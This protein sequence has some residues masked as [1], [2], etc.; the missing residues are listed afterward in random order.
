MKSHTKGEHL[1]KSNV[2]GK[3]N[4]LNPKKMLLTKRKKIIT[5]PRRGGKLRL[6]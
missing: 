1:A 2:G 3:Y 4:E 6:T 5:D